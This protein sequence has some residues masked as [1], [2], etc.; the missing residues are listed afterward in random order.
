M[1]VLKMALEEAVGKEKMLMTTDLSL[2]YMFCIYSNPFPTQNFGL[3]QIESILKDKC[4][5]N[6]NFCL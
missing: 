3:D 4:N 1:I 6:D 2:W 5:K